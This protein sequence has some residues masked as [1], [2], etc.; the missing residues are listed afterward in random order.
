MDLIDYNQEIFNTICK[1][2]KEILPYLKKHKH[3]KTHF[4]L[5]CVLDGDGV[6]SKR[7]ICLDMMKNLIRAFRYFA[8]YY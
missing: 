2:Y 5:I 8:Y 7:L 3:I 1:N 4:I 6:A